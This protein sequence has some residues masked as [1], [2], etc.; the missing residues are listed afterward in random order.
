MLRAKSREQSAKSME[1]GAKCEEK[2]REL[3][4]NQFRI[5][6]SKFRV[7]CSRLVWVRVKSSGFWSRPDRHQDHRQCLPGTEF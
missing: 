2:S 5:P 6:G 7:P 4:E 1:H 3:S